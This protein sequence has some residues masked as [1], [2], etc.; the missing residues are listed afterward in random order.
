MKGPHVHVH[1]QLLKEPV[2]PKVLYAQRY[3]FHILKI[4]H[5]LDCRE[6]RFVSSSITAVSDPKALV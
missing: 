6:V 1:T 3:I 2:S 5:F 4:H